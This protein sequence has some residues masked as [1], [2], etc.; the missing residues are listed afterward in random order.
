MKQLFKLSL[1][2]L[3]NQILASTGG[4]MCVIFV[5]LLAGSTLG[6]HFLFLALTFP[7]FIYIEYRAAFKYGF[8]DSNRRNNPNSKAYL[9]KGALAGLISA[10]P[11][12]LLI[13][14]YI[15]CLLSG[16]DS[17]LQF[18]KLYVRIFSMYYCWPMCNILPNHTLAVFLS[19]L[20]PMII[21]PC[22]GYIAGYKNFL[23][24]DIIFKTLKVKPRV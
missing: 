24:S 9:F 11:L 3:M 10:I 13:C 5:L 22:A 2:L 15:Y 6:A 18:A 20:I 21:I 23:I 12:I 14:F 19:S 4:I 8:H 7:F 16:F 1:S 17:S